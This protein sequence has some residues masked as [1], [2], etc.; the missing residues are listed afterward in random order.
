MEI[1]NHF[2][3]HYG[4]H[5]AMHPANNWT[6]GAKLGAG[7]YPWQSEAGD[8][9]AEQRDNALRNAEVMEEVL[10]VRPLSWGIP[11]RTRDD[12]TPAALEAAGVEIASD[13]DAGVVENVLK[14][15]PPHHPKGTQRL[16]ELTK[17]YPGDP[18][19]VYQVAML[20]QWI[21]YALETG[22]PFIFMAHHHLRQYEGW[23]CFRMCE[24]IFRHILEDCH[25]DFYISTVYGVGIY[26]RD[27]LSERCRIVSINLEGDRAVRVTNT[28]ERLL[29][30]IPVDLRWADGR[31]STVL[32]DL[33]PGETVHVSFGNE[34]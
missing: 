17:K 9:L 21:A 18:S 22:R 24:E 14:F 15:P 16:V 12:N 30:Q 1:G 6:M 31:Q 20:K 19:N 23:R 11:D 2:Y 27:V 13:C 32:L 8:T 34:A 28:G 25:G 3:L 7:V 29:Q 26:W 10:G 5:A 33:P 4:T